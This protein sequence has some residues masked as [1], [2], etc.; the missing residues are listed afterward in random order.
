[1]K[2][3]TSYGAIVGAVLVLLR[4]RAGLRQED[5]AEAVGVAGSTWCR[6]ERGQSGLSVEQ[7]AKA[8]R[9]I[10]VLPGE[11]LTKADLV[12]RAMVS[13][14]VLVTDE[15]EADTIPMSATT[16]AGFVR[17]AIDASSP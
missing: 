4:K 17:R 13:R 12:T 15:E 2:L 8:S 11:V 3:A 6:A 5:V 9:R 7:L 1:M 10:G 16:L 14:G